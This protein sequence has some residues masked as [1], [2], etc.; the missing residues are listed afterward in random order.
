MKFEKLTVPSQ[1]DLFIRKI[2][3]MI[4]SGELKIGEKIPPER[5]LAE[6]MGVSRTI[7]NT[8][9][10]VLENQGFLSIIPRQGVFVND[11]KRNAGADT[12]N[13]IMRIKGDVISDYDIKSVLEI[14]WALEKLA[15]RNAIET[16]TEEEIRE[17][18]DIVEELGQSE[19]P[20]E[21]AEKAFE[22]YIKMA[23]IGENQFLEIIIA[24]FRLP[25]IAMWVR[26]CRI[27]G[28]HIL[29]KHTLT[30]WNLLK[31]GDYSEALEWVE[32]LTKEAI[33][34]KYT[35]YE[36]DLKNI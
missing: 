26:F 13:A 24:N 18:R 23:E 5:E 34:G 32:K 10:A 19:S 12:L 1:K 9:I 16:I 7:V 36:K 27:Y 2:Q 15:I 33:D 4:L 31:K 30:S 11:Y 35:L 28:I 6:K 14:R 25:C 17:L 3:D 29:F 22:F 21:A 8:G 20:Q